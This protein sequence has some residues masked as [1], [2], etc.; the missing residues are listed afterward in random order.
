ML[1]CFCMDTINQHIIE[2]ILDFLTGELSPAGMESLQQWIAASDKNRRYFEEMKAV[3]QAA[4]SIDASET[5]HSEEAWQKLTFRQPERSYSDRRRES[6]NPVVSGTKRII[7][8]TLRVAAAVA[9]I[10]TGGALAGYFVLKP[11]IDREKELTMLSE[12]KCTMV[13]PPGSKTEITLP[14]GT[15]AWLNSAGTLTYDAMFN[16]KE[17]VV[18]LKGEA[19]FEVSKDQLRPFIV[20]TNS[21]SVE[22]LG[23]KFNVKAYPDDDYV[24]ATLLE[25]SIRVSS[26]TQS[27][28]VAPNE[29]LKFSKSDGQFTKIALADADR[30]ISWIAGQ[31]SFERERLEDIA[32]MLER[33]YSIQILFSSENLKDI[34]FSGTLKNNNLENVLQVIS[35]VSPVSYSFDKN[36]TTI[37][38]HSK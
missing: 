8:R 24:V 37:V 13:V 21:V 9:I 19:Y 23:T 6:V 16:R 27:A 15:Q 33:M 11:A 5:Y 34:R 32:K 3:W 18:Y 10:F 4:G 20:K 28:M 30:N 25:G 38:I 17:R 36:T 26:P 7:M 1:S 29:K 22:A 14:D 31:L 12:S 2:Q 35:L